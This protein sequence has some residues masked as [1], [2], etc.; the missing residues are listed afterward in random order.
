[1]DWELIVAIVLCLYG[2]FFL[3]YNGD[4]YWDHP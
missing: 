2:A 1:M 3:G 4:G